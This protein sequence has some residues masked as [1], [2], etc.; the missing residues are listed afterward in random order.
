MSGLRLAALAPLLVVL[1]ACGGGG[2]GGGGLSFSLD[3]NAIAFEYEESPSFVPTETVTATATGSYSG[4]LYVGAIVEGTAI[5]PLVIAT[6]SGNQGTFVIRPRLNLA[7]GNY[8]GRVLLMACSDSQCNNRLG[9]TPLP[10][11]YT[12][13]VNPTLRATPDPLVLSAVSGNEASATVNVQLPNGVS[14][15]SA[16]FTNGTDVFSI[17][18]ATPTSF[19]V[20]AR[21][22]PPGSYPTSIRV[23]AGTRVDLVN[24]TYSVATP[25][26]GVNNLQASPSS[27][28]L[29]ATEGASTSPATLNVTPASWDP[30]HNA[31]VDYNDTATG[32]L[33]ATAVNGGYS[34]VANAEGLT[35]G[36]YSAQI[37][38]GGRQPITQVS[39]PVSLTVGIGLIRP[40]DVM[41]PV[42]SDTTAQQLA[43]S[44]PITLAGGAAVNW[45]ASSN[46]PWLML[47][48]S[49]GA[50]GTTVDYQINT[51]GL[52][53]LAN[54]SEHVAQVTIDPAPETMS[55]VT[56]SIRVNK[57]LAQVTGLGPY[58]Q[59]SDRPFRVIAR[60]LGYD[61]I[62]NPSA[63]VIVE[64]VP[65][66]TIQRRG[67]NDVLITAPAQAAGTYRVRVSNALGMTTASRLVTVVDPRTQV[68]ANVAT[69]GLGQTVIYDAEHDA[70]YFAN[71]GLSAVQ[72][73]APSGGSWIMTSSLP[74]PALQ[75]IGLSND[76]ADLIVLSTTF[77]SPTSSIVRFLRT[78]DPGLAER[79]QVTRDG[80]LSSSSNRLPVTNDGR[81]WFGGS[82]FQAFAYFDPVTQTFGN[83]E[84]PSG[85]YVSGPS[86]VTPRDG[87]RLTIVQ[88]RCCS[89]PS[90]VLYMEAAESIARVNPA[91]L[92]NF[93]AAHASDDGERLMLSYHTVYNKAFERVG[94]TTQLALSQTNQWFP[95]SG[96]VSPDG[97][98]LY[99]VGYNDGEISNNP[100]PTPTLYPRVY[101]F[102]SSTIMTNTTR[103]PLLGYF[104][105]NEYPTGRR[106]DA[107]AYSPGSAISPDGRTLFVVGGA[108]FMAVPLPDESTLIPP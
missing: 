47:M 24:V 108:N 50:T 99:L 37:L 30:A 43:G 9:N 31:T 76:G 58:L 91:N 88:N 55:P 29:S 80:G 33:S 106:F 44:V 61:P 25:P 26:G 73:F 22:M 75:D 87:S 1:A 36:S 103:L 82:F 79:S 94:D 95:V 8:S 4:T 28:T 68:A 40:A 107:G 16:T 101:V 92:D 86:F 48:R 42:N 46:Q 17:T 41:V 35:A 3:R 10:V 27:F 11:S 2:G 84:A 56:F 63:R 105:L 18:D 97:N 13:R 6:I 39:I 34:V 62:A 57:R 104:I 7:L 54:G 74:V 78:D 49:S 45:N 14:A 85:G 65:G 64:G 15:A 71:I 98:R 77:G 69:G 100:P 52:A 66:A 38:I 53:A 90:P 89:P 21:S 81:I 32:W 51:A 5:D 60:G 19:R 59:V 96:V 102:D 12:V 93:Y 83:V 20:V 23:S 70:V 72:R 67:D